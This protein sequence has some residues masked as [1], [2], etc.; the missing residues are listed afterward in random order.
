MTT[1][2][3]HF[4]RV[5]FPSNESGTISHA[6]DYSCGLT[7]RIYG[8]IGDELITIKPHISN[9]FSAICEKMQIMTETLSMWFDVV[10][11]SVVRHIENTMYRPKYIM[12]AFKKNLSDDPVIEQQVIDRFESIGYNL[13]KEMTRKCLNC[14]DASDLYITVF[15]NKGVEQESIA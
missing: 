6:Y 14:D 7:V 10:K 1:T 13:H 3:C 11:D 2:D 8:N 12:I 4:Q 15:R 9:N 5:W